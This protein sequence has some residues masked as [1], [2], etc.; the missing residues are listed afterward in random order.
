[1]GFDNTKHIKQH[2]LFDLMEF[3]PVCSPREGVNKEVKRRICK[4]VEIHHQGLVLIDIGV[5][6]QHGLDVFDYFRE[7]SGILIPNTDSFVDSA[8]LHP[9]G[10]LH[11]NIRKDRVWNIKRSHIKGANNCQAP[12]DTFNGSLDLPIRAANPIA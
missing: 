10:I 5:G 6:S 9:G 4:L 11:S 12:A 8:V 2:S 1:M 7:Q 3:N